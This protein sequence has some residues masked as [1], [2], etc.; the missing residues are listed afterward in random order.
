ML[1]T[2]ESELILGERTSSSGSC[3]RRRERPE[4]HLVEKDARHSSIAKGVVLVTASASLDVV[5]AHP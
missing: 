4:G 3:F 5:E 2:G 1:G